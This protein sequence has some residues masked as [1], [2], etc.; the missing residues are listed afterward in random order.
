METESLGKCYEYIVGTA[1]I[2]A[3]LPAKRS[4][5]QYCKYIG[6]H[7]AFDRY[8]CIV[9]DEWLIDYKRGRG[10]QCPFVWT[11]EGGSN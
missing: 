9:T 4:T 10:E 11:G 8:F 7:H 1:N 3:Y 5:C 6:N 2:Q